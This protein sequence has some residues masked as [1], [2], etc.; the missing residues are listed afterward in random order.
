MAQSAKGDSSYSQGLPGFGPGYRY[1]PV[2]SLCRWVNGLCLDRCAITCYWCS[3]YVHS[4][5]YL[6]TNS[7]KH[8]NFNADANLFTNCNPYIHADEETYS[9]GYTRPFTYA[10]GYPNTVSH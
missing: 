1:L 7:D 8:A 4:H 5:A 9:N 10:N 6:H 3:S 2:L